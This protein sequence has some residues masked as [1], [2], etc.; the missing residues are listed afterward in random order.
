MKKTIFILLG[1]ISLLL[2]IIGVFVPGLPTTPFVLLSSWLFYR[3]SERLH[4]LLLES[5]MGIYIK[6]YK[7]RGGMGRMTKLYA[8]TIMW[9]MIN[10]SAFGVFETLKMRILLYVL[11]LIGT[12]CVVFFVPSEKK[13]A[14]KE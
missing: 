7:E 9:I 6:R 4:N 3:S 14:D 12:V 1:S 11:G 5:R 2:G 10:I 13:K 8:I